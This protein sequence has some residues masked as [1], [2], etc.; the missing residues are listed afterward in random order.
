M[1]S[2]KKHV[3]N[4]QQQYK[5]FRMCI[6]NLEENEAVVHIDFSKNYNCKLS[7]EVQSH[8]FSG[9]RNQVRL[10]AVSENLRHDAAAI[11]IHLKPIFQELLVQVPQLETV[12]IL[13]DGPSTQY[14]NKKLF[15]LLGTFVTKEIGAPRCVW[16]FSETSHGKGAPDGVGGDLKHTADNII[17]QGHIIG[18]DEFVSLLKSSCPGIKVIGIDKDA[19]A[20]MKK[21]MTF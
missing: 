14:K 18:Q 2:F 20:Q 7:V 6:N 11:C 9:S 17:A 16:H 13:S 21:L 5:A 15:Y 1:K 10:H 19:D 4:I 3:F 12:L 8:H